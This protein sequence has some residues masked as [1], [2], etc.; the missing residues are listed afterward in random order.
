MFNKELPIKNISF[1]NYKIFKKL[2]SIFITD[3][4]IYL[5]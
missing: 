4:A 2:K 1:K 5:F 3:S